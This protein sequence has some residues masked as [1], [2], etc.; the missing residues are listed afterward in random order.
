MVSF[1][2]PTRAA[3]SPASQHASAPSAAASSYGLHNVR[4]DAGQREEPADVGVRDTLL[5]RE[6]GDRFRFAA[7]SGAAIGARG[8]ASF[9]GFLP[10]PS[11]GM[12]TLPLV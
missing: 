3:R 8:R 10:R 4:G 5:F 12:A 1:A 7:L 9:Q 11:F 2:H 6:I